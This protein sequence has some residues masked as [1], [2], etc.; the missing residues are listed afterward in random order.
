M[1]RWLCRRNDPASST[2]D[3]QMTRIICRIVRHEKRQAVTA[4]LIM[5]KWLCSTCAEMSLP[6][7]APLV[8]Y[9]CLSLL[10][11]SFMFLSSIRTK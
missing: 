4:R 2:V 9:L 6:C 11:M 3:Y 10:L 7:L 8:I 1:N 5:K